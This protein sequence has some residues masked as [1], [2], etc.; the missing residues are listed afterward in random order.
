MVTHSG[1][2]IAWRFVPS[3]QR[4]RRSRGH[5]GREAG[6]IADLVS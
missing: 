4:D 1:V 3:R 6:E 2:L 5:Q